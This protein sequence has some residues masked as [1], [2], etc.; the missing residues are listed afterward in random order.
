MKR[1]TVRIADLHHHVTA[2]RKRLHLY[3][4]CLLCAQRRRPHLN[5][6]RHARVG[7]TRRL[8][9]AVFFGTDQ[10]E[11]SPGCRV[12]DHSVPAGASSAN[13]RKNVRVLFLISGVTKNQAVPSE[14][15]GR[16][17][18]SGNVRAGWG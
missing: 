10:I 1:A 2:S 3:P 15:K 13:G 5:Q 9:V 7:E 14:V 11:T 8:L 17:A 4:S 12:D 6:H 18:P 16:R